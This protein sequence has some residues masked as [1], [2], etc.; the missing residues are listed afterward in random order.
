MALATHQIL[1][2]QGEMMAQYHLQQLGLRILKRNLK[3]KI[4]E[5]DILAQDGEDIVIVEVKTKT[6][7]AF[8]HPAEMVNYFKQRKLLQLARLI[9][10]DYPNKTVRIDVVAVDMI[11]IPPSIE[12][13]KNAVTN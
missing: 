3:T 11:T 10:M 12:Y 5:I 13:I 6:S 2:K 4:G 7:H 1:G 8:G 9:L